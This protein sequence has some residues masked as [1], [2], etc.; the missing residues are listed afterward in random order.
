MYLNRPKYFYG[1]IFK[2]FSNILD[3]KKTKKKEILRDSFLIIKHIL[4]EILN[5]SSYID[6]LFP[7]SF[8]PL[9]FT[10]SQAW[11]SLCEKISST[12][13][14]FSGTQIEIL[15]RQRKPSECTHYITDLPVQATFAEAELLINKE[16][17]MNIT[18]MEIQAHINPTKWAQGNILI[19]GLGMGYFLNIIKDKPGIET[20]CVIE[21]NQEIINWYLSTF[22]PNSH[23]E[24]ICDDILRFKSD[25]LFDFVYIDIWP[26]FSIDKIESEMQI[27]ANNIH[28]KLYSFWGIELYWHDHFKVFGS[29]I[30]PLY[31][32]LGFHEVRINSNKKFETTKEEKKGKRVKYKKEL[33]DIRLL[34]YLLT[35][36][37]EFITS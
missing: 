27:I 36:N 19:G 35:G 3:K 11:A 17:F 37:P 34:I 32:N 33:E 13:R 22:S 30:P 29:E 25:R 26:E 28:A 7:K 14:E 8:Y 12:Y 5:S 6:S 1:S 9:D 4:G 24:F 23:I 16:L 18:P 2:V 20:I 10:D 31:K 15:K 21:K